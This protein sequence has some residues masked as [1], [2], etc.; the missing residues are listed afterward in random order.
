M[1]KKPTP[2]TQDNPFFGVQDELNQ[3]FKAIFDNAIDQDEE[4]QVLLDNMANSELISVNYGSSSFPDL[5]R[6]RQIQDSNNSRVLESRR[7]F[8]IINKKDKIPPVSKLN[9]ALRAFFTT[10]VGTDFLFS[11]FLREEIAPAIEEAFQLFGKAIPPQAETYIRNFAIPFVIANL[12]FDMTAVNPTREA[13]EEFDKRANKVINPAAK[14]V[15]SAFILTLTLQILA[16]TTNFPVGASADVLPLQDIIRSYL[17]NQTLIDL[18]GYSSLGFLVLTGTTYYWILSNEQIKK[19]A[20]EFIEITKNLTAF[21]GRLKKYP[22]RYLET[23]VLTLTNTLYRGISFSFFVNAVAKEIFPF[24]PQKYVL[25]GSIAAAVGTAITTIFVRTLRARNQFLKPEFEKLRLEDYKSSSA[26]SPKLL[27]DLSLS[28]IRGG[29]IYLIISELTPLPSPFNQIV[30][31]A[32]SS[33]AFV[34]CYQTRYGVR[35]DEAALALALEDK[36]RFP[37]EKEENSVSPKMKYYNQIV[38]RHESGILAN[39]FVN[40][41]IIMVQLLRFTTFILFANT[42]NNVF[43]A[44]LPPYALL[45]LATLIGLTVMLSDFSF[46]KVALKETWSQYGANFEILTDRDNTPVPSSII[47][48]GFFALTRPLRATL[49]GLNFSEA[50]LKKCAEKTPQHLDTITIEEAPEI[51]DETPLLRA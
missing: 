36:E 2:G 46:F 51:I 37:D 26:S 17:T 15:L 42:M 44:D 38:T 25:Y 6:I 22:G 12:I 7:S 18:A 32:V 8:R 21:G 24:I 45:A 4:Q 14:K 5:R 1:P 28:F 23:L 49:V 50:E 16:V 3:R 13:D 30:A 47:K 40:I 9:H 27:L 48:Q 34:H 11:F 19:H 10:A 43:R 31:N 33:L 41:D 29:A 35:R 39:G 20:D